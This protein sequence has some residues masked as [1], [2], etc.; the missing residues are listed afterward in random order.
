MTLEKKNTLWIFITLILI[1]F[2]LLSGCVDLSCAYVKESI[3][4]DGW[5]ENTALRNTGIQFLGLEKWCSS[6]YEIS[7]KYPA[8]LTVTTLKTL[9]L[10]DESEIHNKMKKNIEQT[11]LNNI[12]LNE[13]IS[14]ERI[15]QNNHKSRY[16]LYNG[17]DINKDENVKI[18]GEVWNCAN[19]GTSIICIGFAYVTNKDIFGVENTDN[20]QKIVMDSNGNIQGFIGEKGLI[21][22]IQCH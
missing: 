19:A 22:N 21:D 11:F 10:S 1:I 13:N 15:L 9:I 18:I 14:G 4:S 3:I 2:L 20:W 5:N 8:S 7:G 16:I 12:Q 17:F 6:T